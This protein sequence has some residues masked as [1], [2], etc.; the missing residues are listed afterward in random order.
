MFITQVQLDI[1][2]HLIYKK[3]TSL[4]AYHTFVED[5]FPAEKLLKIRKRHLWRLDGTKLLIISEDK[6]DITG[7]SQFGQVQTKNYSSFLENLSLNRTYKFRLVANP[8]NSSIKNR[9]IPC[10]G[11]KERYEWLEKQAERFGFKIIDANVTNYKENHIQKYNFT[12]K[13]VDFEGLLQ[14][15]DLEKFKQALTAGIG[16]QK[17]Y[18]CGML[19]VM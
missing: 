6:P 18:G 17:A 2:N 1:N 5:A 15:A 14:I 7:L 9:R 8:L 10:H 12:V 19:T 4:D 16:H 13:T 3:L 11:N